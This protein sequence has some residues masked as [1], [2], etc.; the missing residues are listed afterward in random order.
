[1]ADHRAFDPNVPIRDF[2]AE[3]DTCMMTGM[4]GR[5][6]IRVAKL[7]KWL[8]SEASPGSRVSQV[9]RL[10]YAAYHDRIELPIS[11]RQV[12]RSDNCS[13]L[14]FSI[15][16]ELGYGGLFD[17]FQRQGI[18]DKHLPI[19][20]RNLKYLLEP[21]RLPNATELAGQ[22]DRKQWAYCAVKFDLYLGQDY[23]KNRIIPICSK[24]E[25]NT[26][27]GTAR[28]WQIEVQ[29]EFVGQQLREVVSTSSFDSPHD[30]FG[31]V[32]CL[33]FLT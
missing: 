30:D 19:D 27:G 31:P 10:L 20:L 2:K 7:I 26:K 29:E 16:L 17:R 12:C 23:P 1:M 8:K 9:E 28:L 15:L 21:L 14:V 24:E 6:Y 32:S 4:C 5:P 11:I 25:I 22:F 18:V 3:L 33:H 13:L